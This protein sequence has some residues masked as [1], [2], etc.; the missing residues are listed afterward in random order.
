MSAPSCA[1]AAK[2]FMRSTSTGAKSSD[3]RYRAASGGSPVGSGGIKRSK[4]AVFAAGH[5]LSIEACEGALIN[6]LL[7]GKYV[8]S[9]RV[10]RVAFADGYFKSR[11]RQEVAER[12]RGQ[13]RF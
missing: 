11:L 9:N 6:A 3:N 10:L 12:L 2:A 5:F 13:R 4:M 7:K 1:L 8:D